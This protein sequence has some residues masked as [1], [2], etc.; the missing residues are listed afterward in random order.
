MNMKI[1]ILSAVFLMILVPIA[2]ADNSTNETQ[3]PIYSSPV[4][5]TNRLEGIVG[6]FLSGSI[7]DTFVNVV[8]SFADKFYIPKYSYGPFDFV[9]THGMVFFLLYVALGLIIRS[10]H[11]LKKF[12]A[13]FKYIMYF[14]FLP[15]FCTFL[16]LLLPSL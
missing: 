16:T 2:V 12:S 4:H 9:F 13:T 6:S 10:T 8:I 1:F 5:G 3:E 11:T 14:F 15:T 7:K